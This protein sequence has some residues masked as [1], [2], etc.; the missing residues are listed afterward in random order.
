MALRMIRVTP[1]RRSRIVTREGD[2][3]FEAQF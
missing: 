3:P 2:H 1:L